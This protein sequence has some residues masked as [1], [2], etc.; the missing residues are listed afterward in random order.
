MGEL[1][2]LLA[3]TALAEAVV[4]QQ[5]A[6]QARQVLAVQAVQALRLL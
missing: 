1:E 2:V 4:R 6:A 3:S 5:L